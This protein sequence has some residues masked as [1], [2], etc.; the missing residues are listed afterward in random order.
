MTTLHLIKYDT[1]GHSKV[2]IILFGTP[3]NPS[4]IK[5]QNDL[6]T[7]LNSKEKNYTGK[8][9][10]Y[11]SSDLIGK[12]NSSLLNIQNKINISATTK[13]ELIKQI[14]SYIKLLPALI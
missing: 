11:L 1:L 2:D 6:W 7:I 13:A 14:Y 12:P 3:I 9:T 5:S 4:K 8:F 10:I